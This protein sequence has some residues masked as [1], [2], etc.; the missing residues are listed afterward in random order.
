MD[1]TLITIV[2]GFGLTE[3]LLRFEK[4]FAARRGIRWDALPLAW[5]LLILIGVVNY[6]WGIREV[7]AHASAW[8]TGIFM[9]VMAA[10]IFLYLACAAA[11]PRIEHGA[12]LD[13]KAAY[14]EQRAPFLSFFLLYQCSNWLLDLI[15]VVGAPPLVVVVHRTGVCVAL[16]VALIARSRR[17]DWLAV[18]AAAA[19]YVLRLVT[20]TVH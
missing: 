5:A 11:L 19:A 17:W 20:Q 15:G 7:L 9:V 3:L 12:P 8:P 10:P 18:G 4:L 2:V 1:L 6:W 16:V 13:M 14:A